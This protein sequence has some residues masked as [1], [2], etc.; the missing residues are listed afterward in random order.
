MNIRPSIRTS[1]ALR[2]TDQKGIHNNHRSAAPGGPEQVEFG[3]TH[4]FESGPDSAG[5]GSTFAEFGLGFIGRNR[6]QIW[7][8]QGRIR[9]KGG[10]NK[11]SVYRHRPDLGLC[12]A[13][14]R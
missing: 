14:S 5:F 2:D 9:P 4:L 13:R 3:T 1:R 6:P 12:R 7:L 11:V 10:E 8:I